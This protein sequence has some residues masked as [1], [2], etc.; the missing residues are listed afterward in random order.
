[1][2][3]DSSN[4]TEETISDRNSTNGTSPSNITILPSVEPNKLKKKQTKADKLKHRK[5]RALLD[6]YFMSRRRFFKMIES[7]MDRYEN[8][9]LLNFFFLIENCL[10]REW[11]ETIVCWRLS[12]KQHQIHLDNIMEW[13]AVLWT[14]Y[15][16]KFCWFKNVRFDVHY[17][18]WKTGHQHQKMNDCRKNTTKPK[19]MENHATATYM[20]K[21]VPAV[22]LTSYQR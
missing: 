4:R 6:N 19:L 3:N 18:I 22:C 11:M 13:L 16:C 7:K 1:M 20:R 15:S 9:N 17:R 14:F 12:V 21:C 10:V 8:L 2:S 5:I